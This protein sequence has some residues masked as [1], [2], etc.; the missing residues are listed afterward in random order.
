MGEE[1]GTVRL[2]LRL[3]ASL[4]RKL[5]E[6]ARENR[7]SLNSEIID[8][9]NITIRAHQ[10]LSQAKSAGESI[11]SFQVFTGEIKKIWEEM[12][13]INA[14]IREYFEQGGAATPPPIS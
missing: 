7:R 3:P 2:N 14:N 4:H 13:K 10:L 5:Q 8:N 6:L 11:E 12:D 1:E 9:L